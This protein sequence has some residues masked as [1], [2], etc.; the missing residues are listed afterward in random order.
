MM[1]WI[2]QAMMALLVLGYAGGSQ[3]QPGS[4]PTPAI[5]LIADQ[6]DDLGQDVEQNTQQAELSLAQSQGAADLLGEVEKLLE[7]IEQANKAQEDAATMEGLLA[8]MEIAGQLDI[9]Q[10]ALTIAQVDAIKLSARDKVDK[11][12]DDAIKAERIAQDAKDR[13]LGIYPGGLF[14]VRWTWPFVL[15][16]LLLLLNTGLM[17]MLWQRTG[18]TPQRSV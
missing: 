10:N 6:I 3:A 14:G 15:V 13:L 17:V 8:L 18:R 11:A 1:R 2:S 5:D 4:I 16:F 7:A 9:L 12:K